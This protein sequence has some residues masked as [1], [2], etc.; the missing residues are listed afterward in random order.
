MRLGVARLQSVLELGLG[1]A[2][3]QVGDILYSR[4]DDRHTWNGI[5]GNAQALDHLGRA[6]AALGARLE[7]NRYAPGIGGG[8]DFTVLW[9]KRR[10]ISV[11]PTPLL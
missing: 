6:L 4:E 3:G 1:R 8:I 10:N 5:G 7:R 9:R 11:G 2:P